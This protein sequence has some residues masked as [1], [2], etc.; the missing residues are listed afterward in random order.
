MGQWILYYLWDTFHTFVRINVIFQLFKVKQ[1][2]E[3]FCC[4]YNL[5][6]LINTVIYMTAWQKLLVHFSLLDSILP[7]H[8]I[9]L[10]LLNRSLFLCSSAYYSCNCGRILLW[11]LYSGYIEGLMH[12]LYRMPVTNNV[13]CLATASDSKL[14]NHFVRFK[15]LLDARFFTVLKIQIVDFWVVTWCSNIILYQYFRG[16]CCLHHPELSWILMETA[17]SSETLVSYISM[18]Y[19]SN[20]SV[21]ETTVRYYGHSRWK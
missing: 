10:V 17:R 4:C 16:S 19:H 12:A 21:D 13:I 11:L 8:L 2:S 5:H 18:W 15:N 3:Y 1:I 20:I 14:W 6:W 9:I 7:P